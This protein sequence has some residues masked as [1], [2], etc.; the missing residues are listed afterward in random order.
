GFTAATG[1]STATQD[2]TNWTFNSGAAPPAP[3]SQPDL[4]DASDS[5]ASNSDNITN[6]STPT[7]GGIAPAGSTVTI[8]VDGQAKGSATT[9]A[10]GIYM[11]T[12]DP[13]SDGPHV[14]TAINGASP[15]SAALNVTIDT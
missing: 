13:L 14:I 11:I 3:P 7:L 1:G 12:T 6:D 4:A 8:L 2:I 5:G 10:D 15:A 9:G